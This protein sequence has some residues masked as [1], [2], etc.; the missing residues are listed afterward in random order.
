MKVSTSIVSFLKGFVLCMVTLGAL[1]ISAF[2]GENSSAKGET[3]QQQKAGDKV[4]INTADLEELQTLPRVGPAIGQRI[5]DYRSEHG[6]FES[7]EDLVNVKGIDPK[8]MEK[9]APLI[10]I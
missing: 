1:G 9:L 5:I 3:Q 8:T 7:S 10:T 6:N 4:N 2:E